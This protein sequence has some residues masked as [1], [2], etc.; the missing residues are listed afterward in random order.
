MFLD[1]VSMLDCM[2]LY[3]ICNRMCKARQSDIPFGGVNVI[4]AGDFAQ[5][6]P[7]AGFA[8]YSCDVDSVIHT[9]VEGQQVAE[10]F[11]E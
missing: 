8:L 9:W 1:E 4:F 2:N 3:K 6:P 10:T 7:V 5:L 11:S